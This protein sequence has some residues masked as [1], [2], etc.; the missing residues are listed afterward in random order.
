MDSG[1]Q[2]M[3]QS[4]MQTTDTTAASQLATAI[5][6]TDWTMNATS[7]LL[8]VGFDQ[9]RGQFQCRCS[10]SF[11]ARETHGFDVDSSM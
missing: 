11:Y 8:A 1:S 10:T 3:G 7:Q 9:V 5:T 2:P 4:A 6:L